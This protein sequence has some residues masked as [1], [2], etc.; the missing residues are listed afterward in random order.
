[1]NSII[2]APAKPLPGSPK[3]VFG[4]DHTGKKIGEYQTRNV[5]IEGK[6]FHPLTE[7]KFSFRGDEKFAKDIILTLYETTISPTRSIESMRNDPQP[8]DQICKTVR[9]KLAVRI[10]IS[11]KSSSVLYKNHQHGATM[12]CSLSSWKKWA[13]DAEVR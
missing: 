8:G 9:D 4:F 1:M 7:I 13:K 12:D 2:W 11:L 5:D 3:C 10:V 6:I